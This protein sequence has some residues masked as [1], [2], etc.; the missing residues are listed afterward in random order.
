MITSHADCPVGI[1]APLVHHNCTIIFL[2]D[3]IFF[4]VWAQSRLETFKIE[5]LVNF[6]LGIVLY[7]MLSSDKWFAKMLIVPS[8]F[9]IDKLC[10]IYV[11]INTH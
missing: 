2:S 5:S 3:D 11:T 8:H 4:A 7:E 1:C 6:G 10:F 9:L